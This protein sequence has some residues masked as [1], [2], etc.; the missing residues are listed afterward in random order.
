MLF[1]LLFEWSCYQATIIWAPWEVHQCTGVCQLGSEAFLRRP[2]CP[3]TSA[4]ESCGRASWNSAQRKNHRRPS[5]DVGALDSWLKT[6]GQGPLQSQKPAWKG[7]V[8]YWINTNHQH[9][10]QNCWCHFGCWGMLGSSMKCQTQLKKRIAN[11]LEKGNSSF[12]SMKS[13]TVGYQW[14]RWAISYKGY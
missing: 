5:P 14:I 6:W 4:N 12:E 3:T 2:F 8:Y 11:T 9:Q 7:A 13:C 10:P 1:G